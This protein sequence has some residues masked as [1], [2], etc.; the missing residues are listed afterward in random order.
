[1]IWT[2]HA[3][4]Y[5]SQQQVWGSTETS[6]WTTQNIVQIDVRS[7]LLKVTIA[8]GRHL[9]RLRKD[10]NVLNCVGFA[11]SRV[12]FFHIVCVFGFVVNMGLIIKTYFCSCW[13]G[14]TQSQSLFYFS[15]CQAGEGA[16]VLG[17]LGGYTAGTGDSNWSKGHSRL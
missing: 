14:I 11:W 4:V 15:Y 6:Y 17:R 16:G 13:A 5:K 10:I 7:N 12:K 2:S 3:I 8:L 1:M 9:N